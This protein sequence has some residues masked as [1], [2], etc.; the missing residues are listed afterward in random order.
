MTLKEELEAVD[1]ALKQHETLEKELKAKRQDIYRRSLEAAE[2]DKVAS[3]D[4]AYLISDIGDMSLGRIQY[5]IQ[6]NAI[7][8]DDR[9]GP[10][11]NWRTQHTGAWVQVRPCGEKYEDKTYLGIMLGNLAL[12]ASATLHPE[13]G[14]LHL[15]Y[16]FHNPA[17]YVPDLKEIIFGMGSWW[18]I[19][20][21]PEDLTAITDLDIGNVWYVKA[22]KD[23]TSR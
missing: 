11:S 6:V 2:E 17:M 3:D 19:L 12:G 8:W 18:K 7:A 4:L 20:E 23:L 15:S 14:I 16:S 13:T 9:R 10:V 21:S 5:P 1:L 22:I